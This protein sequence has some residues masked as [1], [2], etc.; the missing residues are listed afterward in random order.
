MNYCENEIKSMIELAIKANESNYLFN[1]QKAEDGLNQ[2]MSL[3]NEY[4]EAI[5]LLIESNKEKTIVKDV[6]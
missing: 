6:N 4:Q 5:R 3:L 2:L 1:K